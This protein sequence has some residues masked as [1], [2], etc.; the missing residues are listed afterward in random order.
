MTHRQVCSQREMC[1][2]LSAKALAVPCSSQLPGDSCFISGIRLV[3]ASSCKGYVPAS[4]WPGGLCRS[5]N[6]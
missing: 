3:A 1:P 2:P 5:L 6:F 4:V